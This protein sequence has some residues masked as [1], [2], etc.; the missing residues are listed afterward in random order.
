MA[1]DN[2]RQVEA[3]LKGQVGGEVK[4]EPLTGDFYVEKDG[5]YYRPGRGSLVA[6]GA[7]KTAAEALPALLGGGGAIAGGV[8]GS[9]S[10]PGAALTATAGGVGGAMAGEA[11]NQMVLR[12]AGYAPTNREYFEG[13]ALA[14]AGAGA[15][16]AGGALLG[17]G[18]SKVMQAGQ[19]A[20]DF[21]RLTGGPLPA[22]SPR[23]PT[24][25]PPSRPTGWPGRGS[26]SGRPRGSRKPSTRK[27]SSSQCSTWCFASR[28]CSNSQPTPISNREAARIMRE[29]GLEVPPTPF[30]DASAPGVRRAVPV[31]S[32]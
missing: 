12:L 6:R 1:R 8:A 19:F 17:K 18:V 11:F 23:E 4:R 24:P 29:A 25:R 10:G 21:G 22:K 26:R 30:T 16:Q 15:G 28:T 13:M 27:P 3:I 14:G 31:Q 32:C 7:A 2:H 9:P 5:K 20:R